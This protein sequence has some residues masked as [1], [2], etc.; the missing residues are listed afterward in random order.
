[1]TKI[2]QALKDKIAAIE[3]FSKEELEAAKKDLPR[4]YDVLAGVANRVLHE[5]A[6]LVDAALVEGLRGNI[7]QSV[8][9]HKLSFQCLQI[10]G[11]LMEH[12]RDEKT[13]EYYLTA[14]KSDE[15]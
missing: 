3:A 14:R 12:A 11:M 2:E 1:M 8:L 15:S 7:E 9:F 4:D 6:F 10:N 13:N 5:F